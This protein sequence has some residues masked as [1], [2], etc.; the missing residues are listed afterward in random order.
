MYPKLVVDEASSQ[1]ADCGPTMSFTLSN[2]DINTKVGETGILG[3]LPTG[4]S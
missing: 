1:S 3:K 4:S 2:V